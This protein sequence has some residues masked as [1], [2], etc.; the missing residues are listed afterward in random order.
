MVSTF[1]GVHEKDPLTLYMKFF[2][3]VGM[4]LGAV[5]AAMIFDNPYS[6]RYLLSFVQEN[7]LPQSFP[8]SILLCLFFLNEL[9]VFLHLWG[10]ALFY[11][12]FGLVNMFTVQYWCSKMQWVGLLNQSKGSI[13]YWKIKISQVLMDFSDT[14]GKTKGRKELSN[15]GGLLPNDWKLTVL[16]IYAVT[17]LM[18]HLDPLLCQDIWF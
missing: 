15:A 17:Y 16:C 10:G 11:M 6:S 5:L 2:M 13:Q 9:F 8:A 14:M 12:F 18:K 1:P 7:I 3:P 4:S